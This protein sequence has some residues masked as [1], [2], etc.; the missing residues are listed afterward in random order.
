MVFGVR[1]SAA[2]GAGGHRAT[3]PDRRRV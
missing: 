3:Q 2:T 1:L